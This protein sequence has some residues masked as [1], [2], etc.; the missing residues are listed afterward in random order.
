MAAKHVAEQRSPFIVAPLMSE[1]HSQV[2]QASGFDSTLSF[3]REGYDFISNRCDDLGTD[4]F[5]T[6]V[7]LRSVLCLR[8]ES[9]VSLFYG[10]DLF[11]RKGAMPPSTLRLLQDKGSVQ[12]LDGEAHRHRKR[13]FSQLLVGTPPDRMVSLFERHWRKAEEIWIANGETELFSASN[14]VLTHAAWEWGGLPA[15]TMDID[16]LCD[17]LVGMVENAGR[18]GPRMWRELARRAALE[19]RLER[20]IVQLRKGEIKAADDAPVSFITR[21]IDSDGNELSAKVAAVEL[22]NLLRPIVAIGRWILFSAMAL[23]RYPQWQIRIAAGA[24]EW[25]EPF[26]EEVRRTY[27]FFP[28]IGGRALRPFSWGGKRFDSGQWVMLDLFS[29][30]RDAR[31]YPDPLAIHPERAPSWRDQDFRFMP[32]G[33]GDLRKDHR[34]PGEW[35]T[36]SIMSSAIRLLTRDMRYQ[37]DDQNLD[38]PMNRL[39]TRPKGGLRIRLADHTIQSA[40]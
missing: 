15:D 38:M 2:P 16:D 18:I 14:L 9:A 24:D 12:S 21:W 20:L 36:V 34:C 30:N 3:L 11:T 17:Q 31:I 8:G 5:E 40:D 13:M 4:G 32:Q 35:L 37:V 25:I 33:A 29:T 39:P 6:R 26:V 7:M 1:K 28:V 19:R 27:P 23:H 10:Q 22:I